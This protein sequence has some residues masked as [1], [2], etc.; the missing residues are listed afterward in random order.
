MNH[1]PSTVVEVTPTVTASSSYAPGKQLGALMKLTNA[2][3]NTKGSG[4]IQSITVID[5]SKQKAAIDLYFFSDLP[6]GVTTTDGQTADVPVAEMLRACQ[7]VIRVSDY[8][9][10]TSSSVCSVSGIGLFMKGVNKLS[11]DF[12]MLAVSQGTPYFASTDALT[13]KVGIEQG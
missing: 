6:A 12:Y 3:L 7:G 9:E 13:I 2:V 4:V 11:T 10:L 5:K 1:I 8:M